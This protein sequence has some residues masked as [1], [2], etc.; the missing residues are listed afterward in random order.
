MFSCEQ[1]ELIA[2]IDETPATEEFVPLEES[3][4][5]SKL[6]T[7]DFSEVH[8]AA[9]RNFHETVGAIGAQGEEFVANAEADARLNPPLTEQMQDPFAQIDAM[10]AKGELPG[11]ESMAARRM[12]EFLSD[13]STRKY[14]MIGEMKQAFSDWR[15]DARINQAETP[16]VYHVSSILELVSTTNQATLLLS[17][18]DLS[19][20]SKSDDGQLCSVEH[21][22]WLSA[23]LGLCGAANSSI[24]GDVIRIAIIAAVTAAAVVGFTALN[25]LTGGAASIVSKIFGALVGAG[26]GALWSSTWCRT[27]CDDCG[28]ANGVSALFSGCTFTGIRATGNPFQFNEGV[29][30]RI[31][32][33]FDNQ[34]DFTVRSNPGS[35]TSNSTQLSRNQPFRA[36]ADVIC[37]GNSVIPWGD[38]NRWIPVNPV[39]DS[40]TLN[41]TVSLTSPPRSGM[42]Y[43]AGQSLSFSA[44]INTNGW[45]YLGWSSSGGSPSSGIGRTFAVTYNSNSIVSREITFR[46]RN[47]CTGATLTLPGGSFLICNPANTGGF[48]P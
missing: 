48:C 28:A 11:R 5:Y 39:R 40:P 19:E 29:I 25:L 8:L 22:N 30:Y 46:F 13:L 6:K 20:L 15:A 42:S 14:T 45:T 17:L 44:T 33:N 1:E 16:L 47:P 32:E 7:A 24:A 27:W 3:E 23:R 21:R 31:D 43:P 18:D 38:P 36:Q 41:P 34:T 37:D 10:V 12:I 9:A 2:T 35:I 4:A 26:L